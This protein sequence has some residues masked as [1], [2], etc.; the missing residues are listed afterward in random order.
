MTNEVHPIQ[1]EASQDIVTTLN[2]TESVDTHKDIVVRS[3]STLPPIC[4]TSNNWIERPSSLYMT[5]GEIWMAVLGWIYLL[6]SLTL[7]LYSLT[8]FAPSMAND[9]WWADFSVSG[10]Q[11]YLIDMFND[12]LHLAGNA[13]T[14]FDLTSS[15]YN[16]FKDYSKS[17]TP[18]SISTLYPRVVVD[19]YSYDLRSVIGGIFRSSGPHQINTQYCWIDFNQTWEVAHT[20]KRQKRCY[21]RYSDNA[22][23]YYESICRLI[24]WNTFIAGN[25]GYMFNKSVAS[26][27]RKTPEGQRWLK[28]TPYAFS[29]MDSEVAYWQQ[30]GLRRY[31][32]QYSNAVSW[33]VRETLIVRNAFGATQT[34]S[35]KR[36]QYNLRGYFWTTN[37]MFWGPW[38]DF[39]AASA[40]GY[41]LVRTPTCISC[42]SCSSGN[43]SACSLNFER[44]LNSPNT[45]TFNLIH[46][47]IGPLNSIDLYFIRVPASL[48]NL[49]SVFRQLVSQLVVS[50][51]DFASLLARI[52]TLPTDPVPSS[53]QDSSFMYMGGDPTCLT[54][55]P[56]PFVQ[57]SFSF[58]VSCTKEEGHEL[59]LKPLNVLFALW[60]TSSNLKPLV[61]CELCPKSKNSC[62]ASLSPAMLAI[63]KL[64][65]AYP[66]TSP[67]F[68]AL[69][70]STYKE[71]AQLG[72]STLQFAV[73]I[74]DNS[75]LLLR[76]NLLGDPLWWDFFGWLYLYE[77]AEGSREVVS[78]E[79][80]TNIIPL[81]SD[82]YEP[83]V[84]LADPLEVTKNA[85]QYLWMISVLVSSA[86][87][88]VGI[89]VSSYIVVDRG[90]FV[91]RNLLY[92]NRIVG[93]V[94]LGRPLLL[95]RGI[96]AI[97][98][99]S[100][101]PLKLQT[102][103]GLS[104]FTLNSKT[105]FESMS[106]SSEAMWISYVIH[107]LLLLLT[108]HRVPFF[109]PV[110][111][112]IGW[113][114]LVMIDVAISQNRTVSNLNRE[115]VIDIAQSQ[116]ECNSGEVSIGSLNHVVSLVTIQG[117]CIFLSY[118]ILQMWPRFNK[119]QSTNGNLLFSGTA[120]SF[121]QKEIL[122][123]GAWLMDRPSCVMCGL[124]PLKHFV[125]DIKLWLLVPDTSIQ[126]RQIKW[127]MKVFDSPNFEQAI[128]KVDPNCETQIYQTVDEARQM[129]SKHRLITF[130]GLLYMCASLFGSISFFAI[131]ASN[132]SNDFWWANYNASR[133]HIFMATLFN[134]QLIFR[135]HGGEISI[136]DAKYIDGEDYSII[137]SIR[138]KFMPLH[139]S[140]VLTTDAT[141]LIT[142][143]RG[144]RKMDACLSPWISVQYCWLDFN[145]TWEMA[146]SIVR[147]A[148]CAKR[149]TTN[150]AVHLES[151]LR[152][153]N[154]QQLRSCWGATLNA[155]FA[156]PLT[157]LP[158]GAKWWELVQAVTT[159]DAEE[160]GYWQ[161]FGTT[162]Y[163]TDWQ[164][165][166]LIGII[167]TFNIENA[168]GFAYP[169]TIKHTNGTISFD[170]QT[171]MKMYWGFA[172]DLWAISNPSTSLYNC[173]L[174]R[175][176]AKFAFQNVS[177][178]EILK[179]NGTI[180]ASASTN[181]YSVFRQSIGPFG[182]VDLKRIPAPKSLI[183]FALQLRDSLATLCVKSAEFC[184]EYTGLPPVP[185]GNL[186]CNDVT[187]SPFES[188]MRFL[189]GAMAAC[190]STLNEQVTLDSV[191]SLPTTRFAAA[192][193][194]GLVR[195]NLSIQETDTICPTMIL[196]NVSCTKS[197]I[198]PAVQL[199][200]NKS[201]ITDSNFVPTLQSL[202]KT[203]Q[204]DMTNLEIE[205]AQYGK[206]PNGNILFLRHQIFDPAY[207]SFHF[208]AWILAFEWVSALREVISF[209]GDID[210]ITVMSSPNYSVDSLVNPLEIPVNV[211]RYTR[212]VC[213][214]VT[215]IVICVAT[216]VTIYLIFNKGQVE[217]SNLY[218]INRVTG[219]IWIG[220][221]FLFIRS[222][223]AFCLLSTQVLTLENV[224]D[225]W[226]FTAAS[227][228]VN[229]APLDRMVRVF[230]T[231]LAAGEACWLG[232]VVSDIF[233][234]VTAQYTS[235]YAMKS[236]VI[237]WGNAA[238]LSW[239]V[240]VTH[241]GTFG[242]TCDF[243]QV[244]F[245]LVCSSG[246]VAIGDS[247][248]FMCLVG[249]CLSSTLACYAFERIRDPK[250]PPPRHNS[251][252][253]ASS[254]KFMF[255]SSRWIH[256]NVYY[257]D[258]ASAVING[259]LS[260]RIGNVFYVLDV[261]I[262]RLLVI[263]IPSEE[264][265]RPKNSHHV[266]LF[267][268]IPLANSFPSN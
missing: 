148:R 146:N 248:R 9:L 161:S 119:R 241:T 97:I 187:S 52:P 17:A 125:F 92:F 118:I 145:K 139:V 117:V 39:R 185:W 155:A 45:P 77:W 220:R 127:N 257:L 190:G 56:T 252:L 54:R 78:F 240:P 226:K 1:P 223:V 116:I 57:P 79:G 32:V 211:A 243:A 72:V 91:G 102:V 203:A 193:G 165:Y 166:K 173:S 101:T 68:G 217:G 210:S 143:I 130:G 179:Q 90:R 100:T 49:Y 181:A 31:V 84:N 250:R 107:D 64:S 108:R 261:K 40:S 10:T 188:G 14:T 98:L 103:N 8:L 163:T 87:L 266:H 178:E 162:T 71:I 199:L 95:L 132:M 44:L 58:F 208:M 157:K 184:N 170:T 20:D 36:M 113:I 15:M 172:S 59:I 158:N 229:D 126:Q 106:L 111:S 138:A 137:S 175:Q 96:T 263:D 63:G 224:N 156:I 74:T 13:S 110:S 228:V 133:E 65:K 35:L 23:M 213:L 93:A 94:W 131:T 196:D 239:T 152:N 43:T 255:A 73:N 134:D 189:T 194:A 60:L 168:F 232:Y 212:Y 5:K 85:C 41:S 141:D 112:W 183:E 256:H 47:Q 122:P 136:D 234:V 55:Q 191:A 24:D 216:L 244:D 69:I 214:Y 167:D 25:Y 202:A 33:G 66:A 86:M 206:D 169:L 80:D 89:V 150:A 62:L 204:Y 124:I 51:D 128:E 267:S 88:F 245:Q 222:T 11:S 42:I 154:W 75:R 197:L 259:L 46:D 219:I 83:F 120:A 140:Q 6:I 147:Q 180:P 135:P 4:A 27:L 53:W 99:L 171:S 29:T 246:T 233:T 144:L 129:R 236:N 151:L 21:E 121:L 258:Q 19:A 221:P 109:A 48:G 149:Y 201:L 227:N 242:R 115:C 7:S 30:A 177:I 61:V 238:V 198:F 192:L 16:V 82:I 235:V 230:K 50:D 67:R 81:L 237:V 123:S 195:V 22:A 260:L 207:P 249:I 225:V 186:L 251:L 231:F 205:V 182:S 264:S 105:L 176:D 12:Q 114:A 262:W 200:L 70:N 76:Q 209:Q 34:I 18:I 218:F 265:R 104:H 28:S 174:I 37:W 215:C 254:A 268:A 3:T 159:S 142:A 247:M 153:V 253:L 38:S 160:S 2:A 164:N 26:V